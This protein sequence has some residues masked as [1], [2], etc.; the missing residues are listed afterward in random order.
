MCIKFKDFHTNLF[1]SPC[2]FT[3]GW[4]FDSKSKPISDIWFNIIGIEFYNYH[5][6]I[7]SFL[8]IKSKELKLQIL[9]MLLYHASPTEILV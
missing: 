3:K 1:E 2:I 9:L 8:N 7:P 5:D 6:N 4:C